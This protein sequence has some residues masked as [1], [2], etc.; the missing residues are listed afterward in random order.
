[1]I[2]DC[3]RRAALPDGA[4]LSDGHLLR[5]YFT[6]RDEAAFAVLV[7][8]HG[9]MVLSVCRRL[10]RRVEDAED[11]FQAAFVVLARKGRRIAERQT[12][13]GWLHGVAYHVALDA[14]RRGDRRR[15]REQQV[16]GYAA[17]ARRSRRR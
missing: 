7:R 4:G 14:R 3:L 12:I 6:H 9:P 1:M 17:A 8:R 15:A 16:R 2:F 5:Q 11:A 13:G 10:V